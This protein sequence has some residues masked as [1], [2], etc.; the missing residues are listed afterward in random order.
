MITEYIS[1]YLCFFSFFYQSLAVFK[2][3]L[4]LLWLH[5]FLVKCI[6]YAILLI[7]L[8]DSLLLVCRHAVEFYIL[9]FI[10]PAGE[11][12]HWI[13]VLW[14]SPQEVSLEGLSWSWTLLPWGRGYAVEVQLFLLLLFLESKLDFI[15]S[16][17]ACWNK[18]PDS[19]TPTKDFLF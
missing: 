9:I 13:D 14:L 10:H 17:A 19:R 1:I 15:L 4:H 16:S 18:S 11:A 12:R 7:Y 3:T 5:L 2:S 6:L 8:S